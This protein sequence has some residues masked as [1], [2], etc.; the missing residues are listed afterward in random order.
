MNDLQIHTSSTKIKRIVAVYNMVPNLLWSAVNITPIFV[1]C[2]LNMPLQL[3][4][5]FSAASLA[6]LF[7]SRRFFDFIQ[8]STTASAYKKIG[9][10]FINKF[11]QNG[12]LVNGLIRKNFRS[13]MLYRQ[14][15]YLT[16]RFYNNLTCLKNSTMPR[17]HFLA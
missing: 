5:I 17:L 9:V 4:F 7:L 10:K 2:Y 16:K 12:D 11:T 14:G 6:V 15:R 13:I 3:I 1:F 8:L